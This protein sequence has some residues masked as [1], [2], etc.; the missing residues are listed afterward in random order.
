MTAAQGARS[1]EQWRRYL[2]EY[3][4]EVLRTASDDELAEVSAVQRA[5][6][7]LGFDGASPES[8][9]LLEGRLGAALPPSYRSFLVMSN[10]W[11][12]ISPFMWTMR[13]TR[14]INWLRDADP[15]LYASLREEPTLPESSLADR[16]LLISGNGDA[17]YWLLDPGD[18]SVD[19]EW[20]AY[21]WASW[22]PGLGDRHES[23]AALVDAERASFEELS[24]RDGRPVQPE[25][26]GALVDEGREFALRGDVSAAADAFARAAVKG[27]GAGAYLGVILKGFLEPAFVHHEI[28]NRVLAHP[29]VIEEIGLHQVRAEVVPMFLHRAAIGPY[30]A[31]FTGILTEEEL[32]A[33]ERFLPPRLPEPPE[34]QA[35]LEH[36][37]QLLRDSA[38]E[39]A[40]ATL[41]LALPDWCSGSPH[42]IA[43]V[44][45][46]TDPELRHLVTPDRARTIATTPRGRPVP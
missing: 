30:R 5:A 22:Y 38:P 17:Q 13:T 28:R 23:F 12:N 34:F 1:V 39:Q 9:R 6:G 25:G 36:A 33:P 26:A 14:D 18:V 7:W 31:L 32:E 35:A 29:H 41:E 43:P 27:S 19:G 4:A 37:R 40:W 46:L 11:V 3:S 42:R 24:G 15:D 21:T 44:I 10:G 20:A 8:V 45:L 16:A 2:T